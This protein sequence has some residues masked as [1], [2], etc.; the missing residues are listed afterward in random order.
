[1]V[2]GNPSREVIGAG[3]VAIVGAL[4][5]TSSWAQVTGNP[6][7][8]IV[9][10]TPRVAITT[11]D[12]RI[13]GEFNFEHTLRSN[14]YVGNPLT[15]QADTNYVIGVLD[16]G[17]IT[18]VFSSHSAA[19]LG[20]EGPWVTS[21]TIPLGGSAGF[22]DGPVTE[23]LGVFTQGLGAIGV[24]GKLDLTQLKGH[25][26]VSGV[27]IPDD[28]DTQFV[29]PSVIGTP[30]LAFHE[31]VINNDV[32][33]NVVV[34]GRRI[35]SPDVKVLN[36]GE[37]PTLSHQIAIEF[38]GPLAGLA[39]TAAYYPDILNLEFEIPFRPTVID[40]TGGSL[41]S[42]GGLF[43]ANV[44]VLEGEPSPINPIQNLRMA[45][46]TGAQGSVISRKVAANLSLDLNHPDFMLDVGGIGGVAKDV[47]GFFLDF[48][49]INA[50]G[51]ALDFNQVP[52]LVQDLGSPEGGTLDGVLGMNFFWDRN[53]VLKP[54]LTGTGFLEVSEPVIFKGDLDASG[55]VDAFDVDDFELALAD[56]DAFAATNPTVNPI[57][58]GDI[59]GDGDFNAFDVNGFEALLTAAVT[60]VP[61]PASLAWVLAG[62][63]SLVWRGEQNRR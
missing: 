33:R 45:V 41:L 22:V 24:D 19:Q 62:V 59:T 37:G 8:P 2:S 21:N 17:A 25:T 53:L 40:I 29:L 18:D 32:T 13:G 15:G 12:R 35:F 36:P 48:V 27:V 49:R 5:V 23:R 11:S 56:L 20:I 50:S 6:Q 14:G 10:F 43:F 47:P 42:G 55:V 44:G 9:G 57:L 54:S 3:V 58:A 16:S 60:T 26:N 63:L 38:G 61:E 52:V 30:L 4:F 34:D 1:M 7:P 46:D 28:P 31:T 39:T 51:G